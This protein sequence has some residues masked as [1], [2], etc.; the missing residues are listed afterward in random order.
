M[1]YQCK[2]RCIKFGEEG[3]NV[4]NNALKHFGILGM[5][6]GVRRTEAQLTKTKGKIDSASNIV[7]EAKNIN[8]AI[9][10]IK[11]TAKK[12]DLSSMTDQELRD[13]ISRMN[14]EKQYSMLT[15]EQ[16][17][18]GQAYLKNTLEVAGS[19]LA[20]AGSAAAIALAIKQLKG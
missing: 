1:A 11:T 4:D 9:S 10:G 6:W 12:K 18:K 14:M 8:S 16:T 2:S 17:S 19:A 15:S 20:I 7:K 5:K 13:K 3:W